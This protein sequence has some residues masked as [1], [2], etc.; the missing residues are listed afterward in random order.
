MEMPNKHYNSLDLSKFANIIKGTSDDHE[1]YQPVD[2]PA[3]YI[4]AELERGRNYLDA[5][6]K[7]LS[8]L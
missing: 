8:K 6:S 4:H 5:K 1:V 7:K 3:G 2:K